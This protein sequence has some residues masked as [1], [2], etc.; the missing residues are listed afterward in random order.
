MRTLHEPAILEAETATP[1]GHVL[2]GQYSGAYRSDKGKIKGLLLQAGETEFTVKLPKY[3]RPMLLRELA[4]G[5]FVQVW[6]YPEGDRWRAINILP[7][8]QCEAAVLSQQ[9]GDLAPAPA[10]AQTSPKRMCIEVCTKGKCY[11]QG[12][13]Q[14]QTALQDAVDRDPALAHVA[15]KGTGCMKACKQGPNL[16]LPNGQ[17]LHRASPAEALARLDAKR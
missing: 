6:A 15:I 2:K 13:R 8:P 10:L 12:G 17:M 7:L 3:L 1:A 11:K 16:R 5:D 4:P 14:L 9:W